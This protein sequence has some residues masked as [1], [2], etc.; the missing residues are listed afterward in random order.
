[1]QIL[2]PQITTLSLHLHLSTSCYYRIIRF[3]FG[4]SFWFFYYLYLSPSTL[5]TEM[6]LSSKFYPS[7]MYYKHRLA[8]K[9]TNPCKITRCRSLLVSSIH[10]PSIYLSISFWCSRPLFSCYNMPACFFGISLLLTVA[11]T[12]MSTRNSSAIK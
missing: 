7:V 5:S 11:V 3:F 8:L 12:S 1:M 9:A 2:Q 4:F 10:Y 6:M